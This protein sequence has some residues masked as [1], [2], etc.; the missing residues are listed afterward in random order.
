MMEN[1]KKYKAA[2]IAGNEEYLSTLAE[3]KDKIKSA[4]I[5]AAIAVNRELLKLYWEIGRIIAEKQTQARWGDSIV[6][7]LARDLRREFPD[8]K[9]FS[10]TNLFNI[11]QWYLFYSGLDE[12]VQQLV[13]QLPWGHNVAII[14]K[15][16]NPDQAIFYVTETI[17][18]N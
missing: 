5:K 11:R 9:G 2:E 17:K 13:G 1:L 15:V 14:N 7:I 16:K 8:L 12:K 10:R 4:Q 3:I 18:N 6:D